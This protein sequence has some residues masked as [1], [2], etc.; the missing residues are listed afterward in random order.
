[1]CTMVSLHEKLFCGHSDNAFDWEKT[2][3]A[4]FMDHKVQ[5]NDTF[6]IAPHVNVSKI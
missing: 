3:R 2:M 5:I 4:S 1:M 6:Q